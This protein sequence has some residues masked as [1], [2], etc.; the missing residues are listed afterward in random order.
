MSAIPIFFAE[1]RKARRREGNRSGSQQM[2]E[3]VFGSGFRIRNGGEER[4]ARRERE[5][6]K[7]AFEYTAV[8]KGWEEGQKKSS[9]VNFAA[10]IV[11]TRRDIHRKCLTMKRWA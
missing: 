6:V 9:E 10:L 11:T 4:K 8:D 5:R 7:S 2:G 1:E 3:M